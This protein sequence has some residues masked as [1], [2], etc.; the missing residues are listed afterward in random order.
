LGIDKKEWPHKAD[1]PGI[2]RFVRK[3]GGWTS[4]D[5]AAVHLLPKY[6]WQIISFFFFSCVLRLFFVL[7]EGFHTKTCPFQPPSLFL[8][9]PG[10]AARGVGRCEHEE[11]ESDP[12][13]C[14]GSS[15]LGLSVLL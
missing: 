13:L 5:Q 1:N 15:H 10:D 11:A 3:R 2:C 12:D 14:G 7:E 4:G 8:F 9:L 6:H